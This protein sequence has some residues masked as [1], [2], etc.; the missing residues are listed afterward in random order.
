MCLTLSNRLEQSIFR[1]LGVF[2]V[3]LAGANA[4]KIH[5]AHMLISFDHGSITQTR[6]F[7]SQTLP[8]VSMLLKSWEGPGYE[9]T[10]SQQ[11]T[12]TIKIIQPLT[13]HMSPSNYEQQYQQF[14]DFPCFAAEAILVKSLSK[15]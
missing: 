7:I 5:S 6:N 4:T 3:E 1:V 2:C 13:Y 8:L 9:A 14:L 10:P 11:Y 12:I 15:K